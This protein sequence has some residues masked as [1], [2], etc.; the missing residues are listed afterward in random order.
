MVLQT[1]SPSWI[2]L[3]VCDAGQKIIPTEFLCQPI[4]AT[5][6]RPRERCGDASGGPAAVRAAGAKAQVCFTSG[7]P[8][9]QK[10]IRYKCIFY[11]FVY[12][13]A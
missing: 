4:C 2:P 10:Q 11:Y 7:H 13:E 8:D 3:R 6:S 9:V 1:S 5:P 12:I